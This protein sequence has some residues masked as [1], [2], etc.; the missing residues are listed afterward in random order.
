MQSGAIRLARDAL[1]TP[2]LRRLQLAN[3]AAGVGGWAFMVSLA[4]HAYA[5]GGA[6]A[7]G[8]AALV[9]M[10]PA[11][12]AAPLTG[13]AADRF[14]RRDVLLAAVLARALLLGA[15]A[16]SVALDAPFA[17]LLVL[18]TL[19]TVAAT[20]HKPA[21]AALLPSLAPSRTR[22]AAS[23]ALWT[24]IDNGAFVAGAVV[25]GV[26]VATLGAA[27]AFAAAGLAFAAAATAL[28][29]VTRASSF[30]TTGC[31][32]RHPRGK[33]AAAAVGYDALAGVRVVGRDRRLR[34]LVGVLSAS[35]LVEGMVD[36]LVVVTALEVVDLGD[37]GVGWLN[38]AWGIGG[39]VGGALAL[40]LLARDRLGHSLPLG[41]M[42]IGA[43]LL[44]LATLPNGAA[45]LAALVTLG[46]GYALVE[47]GGITL[48]QR[49]A[50][51]SVRARA[52][53]VVESAYWLTTGA[54]AMLAPAVIVLTSPR[55]ALA[56][57]G[58]ALPVLMLAKRAA[59]TRLDEPVVLPVQRFVLEPSE[60][61][62]VHA[63]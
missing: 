19:F 55:A 4:V 6:A 28:A 27:A 45:A 35:T 3:V 36:V 34:L 12:L 13:L 46:I 2:D 20:A 62:T 5:V 58:A 47:S 11:G 39:I 7:V 53:G 25:G 15:A 38:A 57:V 29:R 41:G 50:H 18:A 33:A 10:A 37:A 60:P 54:G 14:P 8:L 63:L 56:I 30:T 1:A 42:L 40:K 24:A 16:L 52:F 21:Q 44:A 59:L 22:Q 32:T 23:N 49:I 17:L 31:E 48:L 43:P 26:L 51:D 61:P 9:R